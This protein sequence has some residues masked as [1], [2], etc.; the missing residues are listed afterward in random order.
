MCVFVS[1]CVSDGSLGFHCRGI[2][3]RRPKPVSLKDTHK[4]YNTTKAF[5]D[6]SSAITRSATTSLQQLQ[7]LQQHQ[8]VDNAASPPI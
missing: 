2:T 3:A 1:E 7:Q 5:P 4:H 6:R 8:E